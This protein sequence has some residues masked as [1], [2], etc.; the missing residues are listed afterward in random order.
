MLPCDG[1][2]CFDGGDFYYVYDFGDSDDDAANADDNG[3]SWKLNVADGG[4]F[5]LAN[6]TSGSQVTKLTLTTGGALTPFGSCNPLVSETYVIKS[7]LVTAAGTPTV[8]V[9]NNSITAI[10]SAA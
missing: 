8:T 1:V 4:T 10:K 2:E 3:D 5:T 6:N 9:T 7:L